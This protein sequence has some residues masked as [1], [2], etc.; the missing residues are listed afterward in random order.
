MSIWSAVVT[1]HTICGSV[2]APASSAFAF[3]GC[4]AIPNAIAAAAVKLLRRLCVAVLDMSMFYLLL[5]DP[6]RWTHDP[7][8]ALGLLFLLVKQ[9]MLGHE[10][11]MS[12]RSMTATR[13]PCAAKVEAPPS[14]RAAAQN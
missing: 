10:P 13:C 7:I 11:P 2:G 6:P 14:S 12:L 5:V 3:T 9:A 4:S 1:I 8:F